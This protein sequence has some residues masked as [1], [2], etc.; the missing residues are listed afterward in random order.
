[1]QCEE[2]ERLRES[3]IAAS[4]EFDVVV[5]AV[6]SATGFLFD[7]RSKNITWAS[8]QTLKNWPSEFS[9][10]TE[11]RRKHLNAS[12]ALSLHLTQHRC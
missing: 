6:K 2:K 5:Q 1:M 9:K 12:S 7:F 11:A 4:T 8:P 3:C 10:L